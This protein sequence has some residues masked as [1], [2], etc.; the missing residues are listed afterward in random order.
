MI[1]NNKDI[2][3]TPSHERKVS[4]DAELH[5]SAATEIPVEHGCTMIAHLS[6]EKGP[7]Q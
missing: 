6:M 4:A 3:S 1:S 7:Y 2:V 5:N